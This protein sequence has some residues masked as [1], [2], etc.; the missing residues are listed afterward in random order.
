MTPTNTV[1]ARAGGKVNLGLWVGAPLPGG[2]HPLLTAFQAVDLWETVTI[3]QAPELS[4]SVTGD[5]DYSGVPL[6]G[7]NI[8]WAAALALAQHSGY[9]AAVHI[10]ID[11]SV[12][13]A[14]GM[15]GG[16][17]DAAATLLALDRYW[18]L[19]LDQET[20]EAIG[21]SLGADVAF[22]LRGG[23]A[24]G[25]G[26][27]DELESVTPLAALN[28]VIVPADFPLS[29]A[30]V[31]QEFDRLCPD[32]VLP[33][34]LPEGFIAAWREGDARALAPLMHNDLEQAACSLHPELHDTLSVIEQAGALRAMVSGSG[35][36]VMGLAANA[37]DAAAIAQSLRAKGY[38]ALVT[39]SV[40]PV[41]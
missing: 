16:S 24:I 23:A 1:S 20:L 10:A 26:R 2:Y 17:A 28:L 21:A 8:A 36:T 25:H 12:P 30:S 22:S 37:V 33:T 7:G 14:G 18:Q 40:G 5:V 3:T 13:V 34:E 9:Q 31:Y 41:R 6:G 4:V 27:G 29:T 15:A 38:P 39:T 32:I 11:K 19:K 35:P